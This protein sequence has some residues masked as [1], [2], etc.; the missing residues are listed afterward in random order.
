M[1]HRGHGSS[2]APSSVADYSI[3]IFTQD[4]LA[5]LDYLG[6][7]ECCLVGHSMGGMIAQEFTLK[8][9][10]LIRALVL[11]D[12][13]SDIAAPPGFEKM[14]DK[15]DEIAIKEGLGVSF[16]HDI[17]MNPA[18]QRRFEQYP[19]QRAISKRTV[20]ETSVDGYVYTR[21][22]F[23][24][25]SGVRARLSEISVPTLV[26]VG[27]EDTPLRPPADVLAQGIPQAKLHVMPQVTHYP[28]QDSHEAFN[29]LLLGFLSEVVSS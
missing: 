15:L 13:A 16:E 27:E 22:A 12:T 5:L 26:V 23:S 11:V 20:C 29:K 7:T 14:L 8:Y 6:I 2:D 21:R 28:F 1:D 3:S 17:Q 9:P 25:W 18:M 24:Q 10:H 19:R 4:I